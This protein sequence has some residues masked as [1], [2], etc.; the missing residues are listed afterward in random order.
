VKGVILGI[1]P[2]ATIV[3]LTHEIPP[4][5]IVAGAL[6]LRTAV[7]WFPPG[8]IHVAVVDP[9]VGTGR[10]ALLVETRR[11]YLL[12][13][14]NGLLSLAAPAA[15]VAR[16]WDVSR[17]PYR[18]EPVSRTF[19]GRDVFAPVAAHLAR[20]VPPPS[21]G[22]AVRGIVRLRPPRARRTAGGLTGRVL[23]VDRFGNLVTDIS[24]ADLAAFRG[25]GVLVR[26]A[27]H[28]LPLRSSYASVPP[29][30]ALALVNSAG[31]LEI[32][33]SRGSAAV[34]LGASRGARVTVRAR[35]RRGWGAASEAR[36]R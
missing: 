25:R 35:D 13:P 30:R 17:S 19:H 10:R 24:A 2:E 14:D 34:T 27:G 16:V 3:D 21:L 1:A 15:E 20:G 33:V 32:A 9:G 28:A 18:L 4:Q 5:E 29:G 12:G 7:P 22:R 11:G 6:L 36:R 26:I 8:T 23:W 31:L